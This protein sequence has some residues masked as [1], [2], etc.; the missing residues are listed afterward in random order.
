M[1]LYRY[2]RHPCLQ[3]R[4]VNNLILDQIDRMTRSCFSHHL[5][6]GLES[7]LITVLDP[8]FTVLQN[9]LSVNRKYHTKYSIVTNLNL[10][11]LRACHLD[12]TLNFCKFFYVDTVEQYCCLKSK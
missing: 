4:L 3:D 10:N 5:S 8:D 12:V 9:N 6:P 2:S 7:T 11:L 1:D